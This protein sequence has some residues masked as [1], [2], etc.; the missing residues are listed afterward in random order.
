MIDEKRVQITTGRANLDYTI[1]C[2]LQ[3]GWWPAKIA[4]ELHLKKSAI[5]YHTSSLLERNLVEFTAQGVWKILANYKPK[6]FK[7]TS[8]VA[9]AQLGGHLNSFKSDTI[10]AHAYM[11]KLE[12]AKDLRNWKDRRELMQARGIEF[13]PL[14]HLF[15]GGEKLIFQGR[16]VHLTPVSV[17]LYET[18]SYLAD[19]APQART[20]AMIDI[21]R[22]I[23]S[24]ERHLQADFSIK[25]K[26]KLKVCRQHYALIKNAL[27][28]I[29]TKPNIK[30]EVSDEHG[31]WLLIDNSWNLEELEA[32]HPVTSPENADGMK[33]WMNSM[34]KT[35]FKVTPEFVL[36]SLLESRKG[37]EDIAGLIKQGSSSQMDMAM[38]M[39]QVDGNMKEII[40]RLSK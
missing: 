3:K 19:Q 18:A 6:Q 22:L 25:G 24:L 7:K 35:D 1:F 10:R 26:Y 11:F 16:K 21:L 8:R 5:S 32:V 13:E 2:L 33:G 31:L 39:Q 40:K 12:L 15:G 4:K 20:K 9:E 36:N 28:G 30:L 14:Q 37:F 27:A 23:K 29:Y 34:K 17:I 38:W